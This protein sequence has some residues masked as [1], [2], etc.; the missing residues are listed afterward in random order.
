MKIRALDTSKL[1]FPSKYSRLPTCLNFPL[2]MTKQERLALLAKP[3]YQ[4]GTD[5]ALPGTFRS[6]DLCLSTPELAVT[7]SD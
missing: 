7:K 1:H 6:V 3:K 2:C 5:Y 4:G